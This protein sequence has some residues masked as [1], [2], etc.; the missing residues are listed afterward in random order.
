MREHW[1]PVAD[2]G[3]LIA[4]WGSIP[5]VDRP[6]PL[7]Y[8]AGMNPDPDMHTLAKDVAVMEERMEML[9]AEYESAL[10]RNNAAFDRLRADMASQRVWIF[11]LV[12]GAVVT[13]ITLG[14]AFGS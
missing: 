5:P 14:L 3:D 2:A 8:P 13:G 7:L 12:F 11:A 6:R 1:A 9:K 10:D 4:D